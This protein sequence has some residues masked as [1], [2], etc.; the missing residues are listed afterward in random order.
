MNL[1]TIN[2]HL[3]SIEEFYTK[4]AELFKALEMKLISVDEYIV[5]ERGLIAMLLEDK[6]DLRNECELNGLES[7]TPEC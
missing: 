1:Q 3:L 5:K 7:Q 6:E 4:K 2:Q